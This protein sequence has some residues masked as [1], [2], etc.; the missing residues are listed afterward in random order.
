MEGMYVFHSFI[1]QRDISNHCP[2]DAVTGRIFIGR[3][4]FGHIFNRI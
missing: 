3:G 1:Q 4:T 2:G